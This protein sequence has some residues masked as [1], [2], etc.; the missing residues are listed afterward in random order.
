MINSIPEKNL[1]MSFHL[2]EE[3]LKEPIESYFL[4]VYPADHLISHGLDHHQRVWYYAKELLS[5]YPSSSINSD[6]LFI[7]NLLIACYF[8]DIGM[9]VDFGINHGITSRNQC[10]EFLKK[11]GLDLHVC[12]EALEAIQFHDDKDYNSSSTHS[13]LLKILSV[14]DDLDAFGFIGIFRYSDIY[15]RRKVK[16]GELGKRVRENALS[17]FKNFLLNENLTPELLSK[18]SARYKILDEF[19]LKYNSQLVDYEFGTNYPSGYC[20]VIEIFHSLMAD[21][22]KPVFSNYFNKYS[23]D[24]VINWFIKG[25]DT[26]LNQAKLQKQ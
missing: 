10:I 22:Q 12:N 5:C 21:I 17:R 23:N 18:H 9:A 25:F 6:P 4:S 8:H 11:Y 19:F 3:A 2:A 7:R 20:G 15:L 1:A 24:P 16:P 13:S 14:A 26:E